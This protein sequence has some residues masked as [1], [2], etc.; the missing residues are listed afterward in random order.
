[1]LVIE[2]DEYDNAF[3]SLDPHVAVITNVDHDH[4]DVFPTRDSY[5]AAFERFAARVVKGGTIVYSADDQGAVDTA[6]AAERAGA[7]IV[8]Y[9]ALD[10]SLAVRGEHNRRNAGGAVAAA[11]ALGASRD[12]AVRGVS[13]FTGVERRLEV[14]GSAGAIKVVDDY[15]HHPAEIEAGLNAYPLAVVVFQPHTPSRLEAFFNEFAASLARARTVIVVE[16]FRSA[17]EPADDR[18]LARRLAQAVR[19]SYAPDAATAAKLAAEAVRPGETVLVMGAGDTRP[20]GQR[21]L[22][23]LRTPV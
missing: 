18:G 22:E 2:A 19:G 4:I 13:A 20:I 8:P 5:R 23:L 11:M 1:V 17:R 7:K 3:L 12:D 15:A 16:T 14:L 10:A 9:R 6:R 21:V